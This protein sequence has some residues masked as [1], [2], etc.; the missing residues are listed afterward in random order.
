MSTFLIIGDV[1]IDRNY[2]AKTERISPEA[3]IPI[4]QIEKI[5]DKLGGAG[6]VADNLNQLKEDGYQVHLWSVVGEENTEDICKME[7]LCK[8]RNIK[9]TFLK[10]KDRKTTVKNRIYSDD[11]L[12]S[13]FDIESINPIS[14]QSKDSILSY[15]CEN[16]DKIKC[17]LLSDYQKGVL[18]ISLCKKII[19][20]CKMK[21]KRVYVDPKVKEVEKYRGAFLIK[22]NR[23]EMNGILQ[24]F[25]LQEDEEFIPFLQISH[26][27]V[28]EGKEG[29]ILYSK[30]QKESFQVKHQDENIQVKD[31]TGCGDA[32][33]AGLVYMYEMLYDANEIDDIETIQM[34][35]DFANFIGEKSVKNI[36][37]YCCSK[38]DVEE[39]V[40]RSYEPK[41]DILHF[42][43]DTEY[44]RKWISNIKMKYRKIIFTNGCFDLI[45]T[46]HLQLLHFAKKCGDYLIVAI[47]SDNSVKRL[48]GESRPIHTDV[49]RIDFLKYLK[50][51]DALIVFDEDT[52]E[53]LLSILQ[54]D[55]IIKG[56]DY[57]P[58][59][60]LG[61]EFCKEVKIFPFVKDKSSTKLI[62]KIKNKR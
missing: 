7:E 18:T 21:G 28:T 31:V 30:N 45:H 22:P 53:K 50:I 1:M 16:I 46:G 48:K 8:K 40:Q 59:D 39:F 54:P 35:V 44:L 62:E 37:T 42:K 36:G 61:K 11:H 32:V 15:I 49:E 27:V 57:Q 47:N 23:K 3:P 26:L 58:Q 52:P 6:N 60:I 17:I 5:E 13:R 55:V 38:R 34:S 33:F 10:E 51:A 56:G 12:V 29:M 24:N 43:K 9:Y 2:F 4:Y 20:F 19:E 14:S 25:H 41:V